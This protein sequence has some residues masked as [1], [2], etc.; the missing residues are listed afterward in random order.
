MQSDHSMDHIY[1]WDDDPELSFASQPRDG[2]CLR[3]W[4]WIQLLAE[5]PAKHAATYIDQPRERAS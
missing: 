1:L 3:D 2:G 5:N 4:N